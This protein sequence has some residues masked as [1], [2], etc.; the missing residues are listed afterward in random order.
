MGIGNEMAALYRRDLARLVQELEATPAEEL[1]KTLP[2]ATNSIGNLALHLEGNL[3][4][5]IG[6]QVGKVSYRRERPAE[7]SSRDVPKEELIRRLG[8]LRDLIPGILSGLP[9][10]EWEATFPEKVYGTPLSNQQ[11]VIALYGHL[12]YHKGQI[13]YLRRILTSG[14]AIDFVGFTD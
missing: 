13:D 12:N 5:F 1:W 3:R 9:S 2:G 8:E 11:F 7:F 4:E 10:P 6:R 14:K